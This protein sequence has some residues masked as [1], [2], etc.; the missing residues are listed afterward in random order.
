[1]SMVWWNKQSS[2]EQSE[3]LREEISGLSNVPPPPPPPVPT[4][5]LRQ[6][7]RFALD[8]NITGT[9]ISQAEPH[10]TDQDAGDN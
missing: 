5:N 3:D 9:D 10:I 4:E 7:S 6:S 1:M 8:E 2:R